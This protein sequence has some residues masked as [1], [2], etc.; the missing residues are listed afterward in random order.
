MTILSVPIVTVMGISR[1]E[2]DPV[3]AAIIWIGWLAVVAWTIWYVRLP[4]R[5][6]PGRG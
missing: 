5:D 2:I 3:G 4:V 6:E 1:G